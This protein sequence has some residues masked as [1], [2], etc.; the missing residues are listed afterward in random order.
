M[1]ISSFYKK[2][3]LI[4][5]VLVVFGD[6]WVSANIES[7][8]YGFFLFLSANILGVM[9]YYLTRAFSLVASSFVSIC[10]NGFAIYNYFDHN[11][12]LA[13]VTSFSVLFIILIAF[14]FLKGKSVYSN[15]NDGYN[16]SIFKEYSFS[17]L[18]LLGIFLISLNNEFFSLLGFSLWLFLTILGI[19]VANEIHSKG[20]YYQ[21]LF[22]IPI[23]LMAI[24][25]YSHNQEWIYIYLS[26]FVMFGISS[27]FINL[28]YRDFT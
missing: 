4:M 13:V 3:G 20:L 10:L 25:S 26:F 1:K 21:V 23:E 5:T 27:L 18:S 2:T 9:H 15:T 17:I 12:N 8:K 11:L 24:Y 16:H 6:L 7:M 14:Y 28:K 19:V 22:Y